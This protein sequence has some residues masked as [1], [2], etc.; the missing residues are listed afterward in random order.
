MSIF[1][2]P[3]ANVVAWLLAL[4]FAG[5]GIANAVGGAAVQAEFQRWNYPAWWN[6]VTAG[7]EVLGAVLI[8][9]PE[10]R[11]LGLALG[12][13]VMIAAIVTVIWHREYKHLPPCIVFVALIGIDLALV[14]AH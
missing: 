12:A 4:A 14:A 11:I 2:I 8:V 7:F 1:H 9:F 13:I 6:F 5:A 10:T 3:L